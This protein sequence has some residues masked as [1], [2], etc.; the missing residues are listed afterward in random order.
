VSPRT[1]PDDL[2]KRKFFTLPELELRLL[3]RPARKESLYRL[4][5]PGYYFSAIFK[6]NTRRKFDN[7]HTVSTNNH[8]VNSPL[9]IIAP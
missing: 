7:G 2:E 6:E 8:F 4:S 1:R 9:H 3:G 5:Y